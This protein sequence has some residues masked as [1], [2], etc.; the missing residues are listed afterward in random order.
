MAL[1]LV[2]T[3][4]GVNVGGLLLLAVVDVF[5][6]ASKRLVRLIAKPPTVEPQS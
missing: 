5:R 4:I 6:L 2:F 1:R 3:W